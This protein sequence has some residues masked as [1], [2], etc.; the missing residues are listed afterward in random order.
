[1][2]CSWAWLGGCR[3]RRFWRRDSH[4]LR[5]F[6]FTGA[7]GAGHSVVRRLVGGSEVM[8]S[9]LAPPVKLFAHAVSF[10]SS[11]QLPASPS[12]CSRHTGIAS[13]LCQG[14]GRGVQVCVAGR[15]QRGQ[16]PSRFAASNRMNWQVWSW[17]SFLARG[18]AT[19]LGLAESVRF[20]PERVGNP[21]G[22]LAG[23]LR[24]LRFAGQQRRC[25]QRKLGWRGLWC[26]DDGF[27]AHAASFNPAARSRMRRNRRCFH[28]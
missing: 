27:V 1:V 21:N 28:G 5:P 2:A 22:A 11:R 18:A 14:N 23:F 13:G 26:V 6:K 8:R 4:G 9:A 3:R 10:S 15:P 20:A 25:N 17:R 16:P 12:P 7:F 24:P 19:R